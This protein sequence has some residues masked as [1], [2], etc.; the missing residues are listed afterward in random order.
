VPLYIAAM[1]KSLFAVSTCYDDYQ[2]WVPYVTTYLLY[3]AK[4]VCSYIKLE[5]YYFG[6]TNVGI[7][8]R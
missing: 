5:I 2:S 3:M 1:L 7:L 4:Y 8:L 6:D